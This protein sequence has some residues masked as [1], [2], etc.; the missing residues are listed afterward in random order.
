MK[1]FLKGIRSR[2]HNDLLANIDANKQEIGQ[3]L[4]ENKQEINEILEAHKQ[5][6]SKTLETNKQE[7]NTC[8]RKSTA[9]SP[10]PTGLSYSCPAA[11]SFFLAF[12]F[13]H[14]DGAQV[15]SFCCELSL[16]FPSVQLCKTGKETI[17]N[18]LQM[19]SDFIAEGMSLHTHTGQPLSAACIN[20]PQY[21]LHRWKNKELVQMV[22]ISMTPA[23]CQSK[24]I[25]CEVIKMPQAFHDPA[26]QESYERVFDAL[27]Y[28][29]K[30]GLIAPDAAWMIS[31]GEI[32]I[33][34]YKD[35]I[36]DMV[37]NKNATFFTNAFLFDERIG[38]ILSSNPRTSIN[39]SI[40]SGTPETW[41]KIKGAD[42][43]DK[44]V[45]NLKKYYA[46]S[47]RDGQITLKYILL[48][49]INNFA[50]DYRGV[51]NL[52]KALG[53]SSLIISRERRSYELSDE[54]HTE[55]LHSAGEFGSELLRNGFG[56]TLH[57]Y[58]PDEK[59]QILAIANRP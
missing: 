53:V 54:Q 5:E 7:I 51:A 11:S 27:D 25:Y 44:M 31:S 4:Q 9:P 49:G 32:T 29:D 18:F 6:I 19:R 56:F 16:K 8:I 1:N 58:S 33:H 10:V 20:C 38:N 14:I 37:E 46:R 21:Q 30:S 47:A 23:P 12:P 50:E 45:E 52:M 28:A 48:P 3:M 13:H 59:K 22:H 34:P 2:F 43:F 15:I 57:S 26:V 41:F 40:D 24:C 36:L 55:L 35:R 42:N 17:K 39:L